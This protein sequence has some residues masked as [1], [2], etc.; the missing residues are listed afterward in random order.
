MELNHPQSPETGCRVTACCLTARPTLHDSIVKELGGR[1][2]IR[3]SGAIT[4]DRLAI[5]CLK[6]D[7]ATLP[8]YF[9]CTP[10]RL[11]CQGRSAEDL[12]VRCRKRLCRDRF[13]G[14]QRNRFAV[15]A[16]ALLVA[17]DLH[18]AGGHLVRLSVS[19]HIFRVA[20]ISLD[21]NSGKGYG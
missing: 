18:P 10:T 12:P 7:S 14:Q 3:T 11:R 17:V 15:H 21:I 13:P 5:G 4:P 8:F 16:T 6:P 1:G 20:Q 9:D 2:Q 19:S